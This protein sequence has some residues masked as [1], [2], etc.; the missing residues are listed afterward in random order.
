MDKVT[1]TLIEALK[2]GLAHPG[3]HRL[4]RSGKLVGLLPGRS[5]TNAEA[6]TRA[7]REGLIETVRS[8]TKGKTV[9]DWVRVTPKAVDFLHEHESPLRALEDLRTELQATREGVPAWSDE[10]RRTLTALG[11]QFAKD[12][13]RMLQRIE[14]LSSRVDE[15]LRRLAL[16]GPHLPEVVARAV[17]W[18]EEALAYLERRRAGGATAPCP[19]SDL[20]TML[21]GCQNEFTIARFHD[22]LRRLHERRLVQLLPESAVPGDVP[23]AEYALFEGGHVY[24]F[25]AP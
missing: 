17:P 18:A 24:Y 10:V 15:A 16:V 5:G 2:E 21:A 12:S 19:L 23:P 6:A 8:E 11:E 1:E 3:E 14:A 22:G 25:V 20:F 7:L 13:A 9:I 4:Y